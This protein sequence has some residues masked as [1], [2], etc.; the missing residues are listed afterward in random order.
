MVTTFLILNYIHE[1]CNAVS[2]KRFFKRQ[3]A[4]NSVHRFHSKVVKKNRHGNGTFCQSHWLQSH[5]LYVWKLYYGLLQT[6]ISITPFVRSKA[7]NFRHFAY[8]HPLMLCL[9]MLMRWYFLWQTYHIIR[10]SVIEAQYRFYGVE[11]LG[12]YSELISLEQYS[13]IYN[14]LKHLRWCAAQLFHIL[15]V[16]WCWGV[17]PF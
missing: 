6:L 11:E 15:C 17:D 9:T 13:R 8:I 12:I 2:I 7:T 3:L 1:F 14:Y 4:D 5:C 10:T 16:S